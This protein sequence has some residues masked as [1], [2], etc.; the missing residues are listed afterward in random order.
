MRYISMP[1]LLAMIILNLRIP[2]TNGLLEA[3]STCSISFYY[4]YIL[5]FACP[6]VITCEFS[7]LDEVFGS[8]V[9][10]ACDPISSPGAGDRVL[11]V[12]L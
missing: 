1:N 6:G 12:V 3:P 10:V 9:S 7:R 11:F 4:E 5:A 2:R 8:S